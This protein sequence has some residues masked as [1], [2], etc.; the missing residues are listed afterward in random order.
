MFARPDVSLGYT[1]APPSN[2]YGVPTGSRLGG[3]VV[4]LVIPQFKS[5][6]SGF[7]FQPPVLEPS[8]FK[9]NRQL[10]EPSVTTSI[11]SEPPNFEH[12][13]VAS[14]DNF[15]GD[16][17]LL[18]RFSNGATTTLSN[19]TVYDVSSISPIQISTS[20]YSGI[21]SVGA[22][23]SLEYPGANYQSSSAFSQ[24]NLAPSFFG[25]QSFETPLPAVRYSSP[26]FKSEV[27]V[28]VDYNARRN[29]V[30]KNL[31]FFSAPDET[32]ENRLRVKI[33]NAAPKKNYKIIF[34][35]T[36]SFNIKQSVNIPAILPNE[37]KTIVYVLVKNPEE[38]ETINV[39]APPPVLP[40]KPEVY[41]IKYKTQKEAEEAI[42]N[43]NNA[44]SNVFTS[45]RNK[46]DGATYSVTTDAF[47]QPYPSS[48]IKNE[49]SEGISDN[50]KIDNE[51][52]TISV[53][54]VSGSTTIATPHTV[55]GP[56]KD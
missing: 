14:V 21:K 41:F 11:S 24:E 33:N 40:S 8:N 47:L 12:S 32:V 18:S 6:P 7:D 46:E 54:T 35:K 37:E 20:G 55:Y 42:S 39:E 27:K 10:F 43:I 31:Y 28:N 52:T 51:D 15:G 23:S 34:I 3:G 30:Q 48:G 53:N 44:H 17:Q 13:T 1:Y 25:L 5:E 50:E 16:A 29:D 22:I 4:D 56:A 26:Q 9:D 45:S 2:S 19:P 49:S 36:P 38:S